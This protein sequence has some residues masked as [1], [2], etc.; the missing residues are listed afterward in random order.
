MSILIYNVTAVTMRE[1][2][3]LIEGAY[4]LVEGNRISYVGAQK[5]AGHFDRVMDGDGKV[6]MPGLVNAHT[7][8]AMTLLR[9]YADDMNL[10]DWLF[11]KIFPFEDTLTS[12]QVYAGS[13]NGIMEM[14]STGTTCFNDMYF[15]Q[16]ETAKAAELLGIRGILNEGITDSV[17]EMKLEKTEKLIEQT[18][19][20]S[21]RLRVGISPHAVYTCSPETLRR[22]AAFAGEHGLRLH[23]HLS[24]TLT[25][26]EDCQR[27]YGMSP[28]E[29]MRET[30]MFE[31]P[32]TAAHGVWLS[33]GDMEILKAAGAAVVH[34][35]VSNLKLASGVAE[36]P[37]LCGRGVN[38]A[39][40]TDGASSNN[41]LDLFEEI[42]LA[43][44]LHKGVTRQP[45]VLPAWETLKMA[46]VNGARALG[47]EDLGLLKEGYLADLILVDFDVPHLSPNHNTI[48]N[49][50][51]AVRGSD[52][53]YT[54]VD[55][56]FVYSREKQA[57]KFSAAMKTAGAFY[58][59]KTEE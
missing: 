35:P 34:N 13:V 9:S 10:Q 50:S 20:G 48:S 33:D 36:I 41:N 31:L 24:E 11:Q 28:A 21:G 16:E 47:Y 39:L 26:N 49:L 57:A 51:Y 44:I 46:T 3:P 54:M 55:G 1:E 27:D 6:A 43:G 42:K 8:T 40:G 29:L 22:C 17:L 59:E 37:K 5:P 2:C 52:V 45:T 58:P 25:E 4:I 14:L 53:A 15:F 30:G 32:V 38:V 56:V 19:K 18:K 12:A 7:H 23:T